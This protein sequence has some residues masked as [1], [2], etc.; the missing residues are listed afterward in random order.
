VLI[1]VS[2]ASGDKI[3]SNDW[4]GFAGSV[5]AG[6]MTLIAAI[7][8]WSAVQ[9]QI[10]EQRGAAEKQR[11]DLAEIRL[12]EHTTAI[13]SAYNE[14]G[15]IEIIRLEEREQQWRDFEAM[16]TSPEVVATMVDPLIGKD[17]EAIALLMNVMRN[18]A[19]ALLKRLKLERSGHTK[20]VLPILFEDV[21]R[22][23]SA[24][25][26]VMREGTVDDLTNLRVIKLSKYRRALKD[27]TPI[28][29][30]WTDTD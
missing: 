1:P 18:D 20:M 2:I 4:I 26:K 10:A 23:I 8:A 22:M 21:V 14:Y 16:R 9:A 3:K 6:A 12:T 11:R 15:Q 28:A 19:G 24:R 13:Y 29:D 7:I 5:T 25:R 17:H 27:G 30:R